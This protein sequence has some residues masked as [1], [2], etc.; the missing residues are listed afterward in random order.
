[1]IFGDDD[2]NIRSPYVK[3]RNQD[4]KPTITDIKEGP[5]TSQIG[6]SSKFNNQDSYNVF[7]GDIRIHWDYLSGIS[8]N[9]ES[10]Q[11]P[12]LQ[13]HELTIYE[14]LNGDGKIIAEK[15]PYLSFFMPRSMFRESISAVQR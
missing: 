13:I 12:T 1:M 6:Q 10:L 14:G 15:I 5:V 8:N 9:E 7:P 2:G 4:P 3:N 11:T